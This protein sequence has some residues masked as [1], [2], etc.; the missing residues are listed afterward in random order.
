[1]RWN[2]Y[3]ESSLT[4]ASVKMKILKENPC[5]PLDPSDFV[6]CIHLLECMGFN[7]LSKD[8]KYLIQSTAICYPIWRK[9]YTNW[10]NLVKLYLEEKEYASAPRLYKLL[11]ECGK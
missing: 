10:N 3:G 7:P 9:I 2:D 1:M 4:I 5:I 6:R 11:Q 8:A